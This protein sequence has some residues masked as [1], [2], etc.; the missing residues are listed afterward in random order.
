M[1]LPLR[2]A[3]RYLR[4]PTDALVSA[5]GAVSVMGL[6]IGVMALVISMALM[7][8]YRR[9]LQRK[10]L[11]GNAEVFVYQI[12]G[13]I[14]E[15]R[16]LLDLIE[17][18]E[19]VAQA[20]PVVFKSGVVTTERNATG[21]EV[22]IKGIEPSRA[23]HSPMLARVIGPT[24]R[25]ET[26]EGQR[27]VTVGKY[28]ASRLGVE[29]GSSISVTVPSD[30]SGNFMPRTASFVVTNVFTTGF[31]EYDAKWLFIDFA[32][33]QSL[34]GSPG[35][36]NLVEVKL[37]PDADLQ[38]VRAQLERRTDNRY[39]VSDWRDMNRQLFTMLAFQQLILFIVIGLIV[40]VS[41]FNI[42]STLIMTVHE[43]RKEIGILT[44]MG[45]EQKIVRRIFLWYGTLV[46]VAGTVTGLI[47]GSVICWVITRYE[48]VSF[49]PEIAEVYFVS[50]IPF[51][52]RPADLSIIALFSVAVAFLA[53]IVPAARAARLNP[54]EALRYE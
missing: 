36:A 15:P 18:T 47:L 6:V 20:S 32:E 54:V 11:G 14:E 51:V 26:P 24:G 44:S 34:S 23:K 2:I 13:A 46:G 40:F 17:N 22:M 53:T 38:R 42:V 12:A 3:W 50:S 19:G 41:T 39:A 1:S 7:T 45:A 25:F 30:E 28:L 5:V 52:T 8:G 16:R 10:L 48:L 35:A 4:R 37:D 27:G 33:A 31:Y 9:D 29:R 49:P 21:S 43:K